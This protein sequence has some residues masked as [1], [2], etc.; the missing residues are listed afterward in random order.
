MFPGMLHETPVRFGKKHASNP[1]GNS[2]G[3]CIYIGNIA[4]SF[5]GWTAT[6]FSTALLPFIAFIYAAGLFLLNERTNKIFHSVKT[7][8][9]TNS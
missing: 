7:V 8:V 4:P 9:Y 6:L 1:H 2:N 5:F 3:S